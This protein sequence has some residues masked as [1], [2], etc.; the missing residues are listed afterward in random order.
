MASLRRFFVRLH[1]FL[2][3]GHG[4]GELAREL[5]SHVSLLEDEF[6]RRGLTPE[7]AR[8]AARRATG[9]VEQTKDLHRDARSF[10]WLEATRRDVKHA[11]RSLVR[12]PGFTS[13]AV[14]TLALAIAANSAIFS[15]V[16]AILLRPLPIQQPGELVMAWESDPARNTPIV[17]VAYRQFEAW[18]HESRSF[19]QLAALGSSSW[20]VLLEERG[21]PVRLASAGVS[22]SFFDTLGTPPLLGRVLVPDDDTSK[23]GSVVVLSHRLW[24]ERFG[25]D[26]NV[27]GA[28]VTLDR[29]PHTVVGV[30]PRDFDFPRGTDVWLPVLPVLVE[31]SAAWKADALENVRVLYVIGRLREAVTPEMAREELD[32]R[33]KRPSSQNGAPRRAVV[34]PFL[35]YLIGPLRAGLWWL[36]AAVV[37]LLVV[38]CANLSGLV[39]TRAALRRREQATRLA[40]GATRVDLARGWV[41]EILMLAAAGGALGLLAARG[42]LAA[43]VRLAPA[44]VPRLSDVAIDLPTVGFTLLIVGAA[45]TLCSAAPILRTDAPNIAQFLKDAARATAGRRSHQMRS[46]LVVVQISLAV[47][48]LV[49]AGLI[50]R[51]FNHLRR[52]DLGFD[53]FNVLTMQV[54][55]GA[56]RLPA[57]EWFGELIERVEALP[58]VEAAGAVFLRP[59]A[60]GPIGTE[61]SVILEGQPNTMPEAADAAMQNPQLNVQV[62]TPGYFRAMRIP[63]LRGRLFDERD[64]AGAPR[65]VVVGESAARRLWPGENPI[66]KRLNTPQNTAEGAI[67]SAW[68]TVIGV[69]KDVHYRGIGDVRLDMY[70]PAAQSHAEPE[71]LVVRTFGDALGM[72]AAVQGRARAFDRRVVVG[73]IATLETIVTRALAPWRLS[74]WML[75]LFAA[76]AFVL[77]MVGLGGLVS[78]DVANRS[79]EFAVRVALGAAPGD[80]SRI[81]LAGAGKRACVGLAIGLIVAIGG[82]RALATFLF[83]VELL[84]GVTYSAVM[85]LVVSVVT[86]ASYVPARR[87]ALI[88]PM[89]LLRHE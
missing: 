37:L 43:I 7:E 85:A 71:F 50:V 29:K 5:A 47:V 11:A 76:L 66:G 61:T 83:D 4:E 22:A 13:A 58:G 70:E 39:L 9:G 75:A 10:A 81:V 73:G 26:P 41:V 69:V 23:A 72:A 40:L 35:D 87:A 33:L 19:V 52:L 44:D 20:P 15:V 84:D 64:H 57:H 49:S 27:V 65:V 6:Q 46:P 63:L 17:E 89:A 56:T 30:M 21:D 54:E 68:H 1:N 32:G 24:F 59:L 2:R 55:P 28:T 78:L 34:V 18:S 88:E 67:T 8:L 38:A 3:P 53:Q 42:L 77:A 16:Y 51:S 79:P 36:L 74:S 12:H 48:L 45:A 31:S 80:I 82:T 60:Y 14:T 25:G 62:A 86:V